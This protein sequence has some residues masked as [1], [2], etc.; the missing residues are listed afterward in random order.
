VSDTSDQHFLSEYNKLEKEVQDLLGPMGVLAHFAWHPLTP[1]EIFWCT[2]LGWVGVLYTALVLHTSIVA[3][4]L[5]CV[6]THIVIHNAP[7][8]VPPVLTK[9]RH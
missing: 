8:E 1:V 9:K 3:T 4:G 7:V 2:Y 6:K 5:F